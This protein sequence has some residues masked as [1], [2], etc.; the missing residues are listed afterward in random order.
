M[1]LIRVSIVSHAYLS[2]Q[3]QRANLLLHALPDRFHRIRHYGFLA[4]RRRA[5]KLALCRKL[6]DGAGSGM[7]RRRTAEAG[8]KVKLGCHVLRATGIT[9]YL[10]ADGTLENAQAMAAH[11]SPPWGQSRN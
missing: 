1:T 8:F 2:L 4:N 9:S 10:D 3:R 7:V 11:E 5:D 6:L